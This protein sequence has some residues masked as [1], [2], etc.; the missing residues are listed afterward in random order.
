MWLNNFGVTRHG[1]VVFYDYDEICYLTDVNFRDI[2]KS[3]HPEDGM[4]SEPW[5]S[6]ADIDVFSEEFQTFWCSSAKLCE[7]FSELHAE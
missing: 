4:S 7:F 6:V 2:P 3:L 5:Y 1:R